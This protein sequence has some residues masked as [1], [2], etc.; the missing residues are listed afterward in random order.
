MITPNTTA[1]RFLI[2]TPLVFAFAATIFLYIFG[3][4]VLPIDVKWESHFDQILL[5]IILSSAAYILHPPV[6]S[7]ILPERRMRRLRSVHQLRDMILIVVVMLAF[8][9]IQSLG[10]IVF[11]M[12]KNFPMADASLARWDAALGLD[13]LGYF[14]WVHDYPLVSKIL[15]I[16]YKSMTPF[17]GIGLMLLMLINRTDRAFVMLHGFLGTAFICLAI[18]AFFPALGAT[19][20][21]ISDLGQF[22]NFETLPGSYAVAS[23]EA[24][25][26]ATGPI[27]FDPANMPGLV[28][29]PSFHTAGIIAIAFAFRRTVLEIPMWIYAA[30]VIASTPVIGGHYMVDVLFGGVIGFAVCTAVEKWMYI[31]RSAYFPTE[32]LPDGRI[33]SNPITT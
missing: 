13:W 22:P 5:I 10:H 14:Q 24:L 31:R 17:T 18:G 28:T 8:T 33:Y 21:L 26:S 23:I 2:S 30:V 12:T 19:T 7:K 32:S 16:A 4:T 25:R 15:D 11:V 6:L 9:P 27:L 1:I 3:I 20:Y 29:F